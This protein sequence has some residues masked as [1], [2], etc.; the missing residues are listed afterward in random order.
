M[1]SSAR[2]GAADSCGGASLSAAFGAAGFL[3]AA[4][5]VAAFFGAAFFVAAFLGA[6]FLAAGFFVAFFLEADF[7][8]A[9]LLAA[10][11]EDESEISAPKGRESDALEVMAFEVKL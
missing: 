3:T 2:G 4:F 7:F 1:D 11:P 6:A 10:L 8:L 9:G 5:F